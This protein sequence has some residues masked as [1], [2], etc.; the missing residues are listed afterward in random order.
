MKI[1]FSALDGVRGLAAIV[2]MFLHYA[3][4][5]GLNW[6]PRAW[7]AVDVFFI[8][9]GFVLMHSYGQRILDRRINF[10]VF[11]KIRLIRLIPLFLVGLF[12][13]GF[14]MMYSCQPPRGTCASSIMPA[15]TY[16]MFVLPYFN[17]VMWPIG[18]RVSQYY[19]PLNQPAWSLFFELFINI[20]FFYWIVSTKTRHLWKLVG[21]GLFSLVA[22]YHF[23]GSVNVGFAPN[24]FFWGFARVFYHFF[25]GILIC[26][27]YQKYDFNSKLVA[28]M[29]VVLLLT[30]YAFDSSLV[31][32][33]SLF[34]LAPFVVLANAKIT[35]NGYVES[36]CTWLG[37]ISYP[38][39]IVH[40]PIFQLLYLFGHLESLTLS[41]RVFVMG[42]IAV[43][44]AWIF[45]IIDRKVRVILTRQPDAILKA[46]L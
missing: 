35:F 33:F 13:G 17:D 22:I 27:Q 7:M 9:S 39:Y 31:S 11:L 12:L 21:L 16:G 24:N 32:M 36:V 3:G 43:M 34:L 38:L 28:L 10:L 30:S 8:M 15:M 18:V 6:L 37:D 25:V 1:R 23:N 40:W 29:S 42:M 4:L 14:S 20:V 5:S 41:L 46:Q 26:T 44:F 19:F 45:S 2:V